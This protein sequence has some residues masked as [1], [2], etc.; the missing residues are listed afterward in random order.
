[1]S[2]GGGTV[3]QPILGGFGDLA[4]MLLQGSSEIAQIN[5][6]ISKRR[7]QQAASLA[8]TISK[9][10]STGI[11]THD[12]LI[13]QG[14]RDAVNRLAQAFEANKRGEISLSE[15]SA[16]SS[17][18][19]SEVGILSNM[20]KLQD[21]NLKAIKK[22]IDDGDDDSISFDYQNNLWYTDPN[23]KN[24]V[25][26]SPA[27]NADG[28]I[29]TN[30]DGS[31][32]MVRRASMEGLQT[33]RINGVLSVVKIKEVPLRDE[34]GN[35]QFDPNTGAPLTTNKT[36][37]QPLTEF[38]NPSLKRVSR[39][40]LV[41]DVKGFQ[42]ITGDRFR[43]VDKNTGEITNM[44]YSQ[45]GQTANGTII[46]GY[47]IEQE[48]FPDMI[49]Q[50]ENYIGNPKDDEVISIL[51]SYMKARADWQPDYG[52]P[53]TADEVNDSNLMEIVVNGEK[54]I[55][56]KYYDMNG[57]S[58]TFTSDPLDLQT[59]GSGKIM[60][61]EEQRELAKAFKRDH[62]LKSFNV[63]Y[64]DYKEYLDGKKP[65]KRPAVVS[66]NQATWAKST[67]N[68]MNN[69]NSIDADYL[70]NRLGI[71]VIGRDEFSSGTSA[72]ANETRSAIATHN[73]GQIVNVSQI[74]A[75][76]GQV[77]NL[78]DRR[79]DVVGGF[80]LVYASSPTKSSDDIRTKIMQDLKGTTASGGKLE[81]V[82]NILF[83]DQ[84]IVDGKTAA[85]QVLIEGTIQLASTG[86]T[87]TDASASGTGTMSQKE[88]IS[89]NDFY[90]VDTSELPS[91]Y[92]KLW[93]QGRGPKSFR[94]ILEAKGFNVD[95][96]FNGSSNQW[97]KAFEAYTEELN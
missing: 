49:R 87:T 29:K 20:A 58:L 56:P 66:Y 7:D 93:D 3:T 80:S 67:A 85:A 41:D 34:N 22:G 5:L 47:T 70:S 52:I 62:M 91:L 1:M 86:T 17:Q 68:G 94:T 92:R 83:M 38:L 95:G 90:V 55:L 37:S 44:P 15:V 12:K 24:D 45:L 2:Y 54:T 46:Q 28:T 19:D 79:N 23:L 65:T 40:D 11:T 10:T 48:N 4:T 21:E 57:D 81:S 96:N 74:A 73:N 14:A 42:S 18:L 36:F 72:G 39:Y 97:L 51:H 77:K 33:Q 59:D 78:Y 50:V 69:S 27:T 35:P 43:Y 25:F 61:T 32:M 13:Q 89:V 63:E 82:Q 84:G 9:I 76:T 64:K 16:M 60:V 53:R 75:S 30:P 6:E 8:E 71:A 88:G 26:L 31:P